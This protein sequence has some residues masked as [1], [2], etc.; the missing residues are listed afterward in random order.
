MIARENVVVAA[1]CALLASC[2]GGGGGGTS[3]GHV[4]DG[5]ITTPPALGTDYAPNF[6]ATWNGTLTVNINGSVNS[7]PVT[8]PIT[9]TDVNELGLAGLCDE[10]KAVPA[11][12][13]SSSSFDTVCYVCPP[14]AIT[15]CSSM[16][17]TYQTGSATLSAGTLDLTG[18]GTAAGCGMNFQ[19]TFEFVSGLAVRALARDGNAR[20]GTISDILVGALSR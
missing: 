17:I 13:K 19:L 14:A 8:L 1:A 20:A 4:C 9:R 2:G 7:A 16:V 5:A 10:P 12:V 3:E 11:L 15:G 18:T 6:V